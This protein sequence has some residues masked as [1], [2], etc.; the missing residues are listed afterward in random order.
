[1][2]L[3]SGELPEFIGHKL[4]DTLYLLYSQ[5][6]RD[7]VSVVDSLDLSD[8]LLDSAIG[9]YD[10]SVYETM[11]ERAAQS[12]LN[13]TDVSTYTRCLLLLTPNFFF[14]F[15]VLFNWWP[16]CYTAT[17]FNMFNSPDEIRCSARP[18]SPDL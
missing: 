18:P 1:M 12:A 14:F 13:T 8:A 4:R 6:R 3:L 17:E 7:A 11:Y 15:R 16:T 9:R 2:V 5:L 10:G